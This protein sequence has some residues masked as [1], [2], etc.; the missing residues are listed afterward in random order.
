MTVNVVHTCVTDVN[1]AYPLEVSPGSAQL[2]CGAAFNVRR[3]RSV[4]DLCPHGRFGFRHWPF[5]LKNYLSSESSTMFPR[6]LV[7]NR[8]SQ[9]ATSSTKDDSQDRVRL[10]EPLLRGCLSLPIQSL[11]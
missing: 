10:G 9:A 11:V 8:L 5:G 6:N 3:N 2:V 7:M 1:E 4:W